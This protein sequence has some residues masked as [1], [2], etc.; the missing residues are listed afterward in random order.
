M[1]TR[2]DQWSMN[3]LIGLIEFVRGAPGARPDLD[4]A[5]LARVSRES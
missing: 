3:R 1:Q 2:I 5:A 4:M